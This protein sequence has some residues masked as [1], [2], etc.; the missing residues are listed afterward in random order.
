M[1]GINAKKGIEEILPSESGFYPME[2]VV[3]GEGRIA[4]SYWSAGEIPICGT[5]L[6]QRKGSTGRKF[7]GRWQG[8]TTGDLS[9]DEEPRFTDG[10][11][12][13][14]RISKEMIPP[15]EVHEIL[16][17]MKNDGGTD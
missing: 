3:S 1:V 9:L 6:L 5:C 4:L 17:R 13:F 14:L 7:V 10:R 12:E 15:E 16:G 2:G 8:Y 11:V